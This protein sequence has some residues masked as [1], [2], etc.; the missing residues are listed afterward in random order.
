MKDESQPWPMWSKP[1]P[2]EDLGLTTSGVLAM[3]AKPDAEWLDAEEQLLLTD[4]AS[5]MPA[6]L[7][8]IEEVEGV[9]REV[10]KA[11]VAEQREQY[12]QFDSHHDHAWSKAYRDLDLMIAMMLKSMLINDVRY[13]DE[14][15]LYWFRTILRSFDFTPQFNIDYYTRLRS[16]F[17]QRLSPEAFKLMLPFL[18]RTIEVMG[19][20]PEP[21]TPRV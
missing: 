4:Y 7:A 20:F 9:C 17:E 12:Q 21:A 3:L 11:V 18:D 6:R 16:Q 13:L 8:A 19:D 10:C 2:A 14:E 1:R 5:S 15:V